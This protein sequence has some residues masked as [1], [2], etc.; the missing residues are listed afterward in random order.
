MAAEFDK[1]GTIDYKEQSLKASKL[2]NEMAKNL[3]SVT[4]SVNVLIEAVKNNEY[5]SKE[6]LSLLDLKNHTF[7]SYMSNL[8]FT[9]LLKLSGKSLNGSPVVDRLI[10]ER[11]VIER[12]RPYETKLKH[13]IEKYLKADGEGAA[14]GSTEA[15]NEAK[16][17]TVDDFT[18]GDTDK[19]DEEQEDDENLSSRGLPIPGAA[20]EDDS[21]RAYK[22]P[23]VSQNKFSD[24]RDD[25]EK[26]AEARRRLLNSAMMQDALY[27]HRLEPDVIEH[28][29]ALQRKASKRRAEIT[30]YEEE[31]LTRLRLSKKEKAALNAAPTAGA[32]HGELLGFSDV[33][34]L[35]GSQG[36]AAQGGN[37]T[38]KKRKHSG[39]SRRSIKAKK[40]RNRRM[41]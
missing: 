40:K 8:M 13:Q 7:M 5:D 19:E 17:L 9:T 2:L 38:S 15:A 36:G 14:D 10:E 20:P 37:K 29:N 32:M 11:I 26:V 28:S 25:E 31:N 39:S 12:L 27:E 1:N 22:V 41:I 21:I 6:G 33:A 18:A 16:G 23:R 35:G 34:L 24:G 3:D 30:K 4:N